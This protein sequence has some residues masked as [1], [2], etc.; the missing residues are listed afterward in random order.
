MIDDVGDFLGMELGVDGHRGEPGPP[1]RIQRLEI[2]RVVL[3]QQRDAVAGREAE[4]AQMA[5][6]AGHARGELAV[7]PDEPIAMQQRGPVG[8]DARRADEQLGQVHG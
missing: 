6:E 7:A 5:S 3:H 1:R 2:R 4:R 8:M